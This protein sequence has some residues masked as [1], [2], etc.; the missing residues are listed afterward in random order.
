MTFPSAGPIPALPAA[1]ATTANWM[2]PR[3]TRWGEGAP[4]AI[5][6]ALVP[7]FGAF[8]RVLGRPSCFADGSNT[9]GA[10]V[11]DRIRGPDG[12]GHA[13]CVLLS[14]PLSW[15]QWV[16]LHFL[17]IGWCREDAVSEFAREWGRGMGKKWRVDL[18][19][20]FF[21]GASLGLCPG[22]APER[23]CR[24]AACSG[25][26]LVANVNTRMFKLKFHSSGLT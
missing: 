19:W 9:Q 13:S 11:F 20:W 18:L 1:S 16:A 26:I 5:F 24:S 25:K 6:E 12:A 7:R 2:L 14:H 22:K 10:L 8:F 15:C 17:H 23:H 3:R 4:Y 21:V